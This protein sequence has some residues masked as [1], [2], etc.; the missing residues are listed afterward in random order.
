MDPTWNCI[1]R[2]IMRRVSLE[3]SLTDWVAA[4][5]AAGHV[6]PEVETPAV[7]VETVGPQPTV[8]LPSVQ[9]EPLHGLPNLPKVVLLP[10]LD[11]QELQV[12]HQ[13]V[14]LFIHLENILVSF[15]ICTS[16]NYFVYKYK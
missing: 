12:H 6:E 10:A 14:H 11:L 5:D 7:E 15:R 9:D 2:M 8:G 1:S 3:L 4:A 13:E 16:T